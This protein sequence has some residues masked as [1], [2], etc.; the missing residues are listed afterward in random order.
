MRKARIVVPAGLATIAFAI[1]IVGSALQQSDTS[2]TQPASAR[3]PAEPRVPVQGPVYDE[4]GRRVLM[5]GEISLHIPISTIAVSTSKPPEINLVQ[6]TLCWPR[7]QETGEC[8]GIENVVIIYLQGGK[9]RPVVVDGTAKL[10]QE[11]PLSDGPFESG[12]QGVW[13]FLPSSES[14][15]QYA[16]IEPDHT[17]RHVVARCYSGPR[18]SSWIHV[19]PGLSAHYDFDKR[20]LPIWPE[21]DQQVRSFVKSF[22]VDAGVD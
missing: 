4:E 6:V 22:L 19:V 2:N 20:N 15:H 8:P 9:R 13:K 18:C 1:L 11:L 10:E 14:V 12:M 21:I 3:G 5:V 17:G 16:I 7:D